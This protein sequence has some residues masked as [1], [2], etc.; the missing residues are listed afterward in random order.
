MLLLIPLLF[1]WLTHRRL[2]S[3]RAVSWGSRWYRS[4]SRVRAFVEGFGEPLLIRG[5]QEDYWEREITNPLTDAGE[6]GGPA[7][8]AANTC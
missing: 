1:E 6:P 2:S 8:R 3:G 4:A 5:Q 7:G